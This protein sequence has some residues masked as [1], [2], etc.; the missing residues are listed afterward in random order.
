MLAD[1]RFLLV[2]ALLL[3][4]ASAQTGPAQISLL[5]QRQ[6]ALTAVRAHSSQH[7][8]HGC[9]GNGGEWHS[10]VLAFPVGRADRV[11]L[12]NLGAASAYLVR[13]G[14]ARLIWCGEATTP[15]TSG[16]NP[17]SPVLKALKFPVR[18]TAGTLPV[19]RG[20]LDVI[21]GFAG[22]LTFLRLNPAGRVVCQRSTPD[23]GNLRT[24]FQF[25]AREH[26]S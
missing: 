4:P 7:A 11:Y 22:R 3:S 10:E 13:G 16:W 15:P 2:A 21:Q 9:P 18:T 12:F 1:M 23:D 6:V 26:C 14:Q 25:D 20:G 8:G 19:E 24:A 5:K 17:R